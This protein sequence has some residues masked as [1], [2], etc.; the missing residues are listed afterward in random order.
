M[1]MEMVITKPAIV[2]TVVYVVLTDSLCRGISEGF[3]RQ[4]GSKHNIYIYY[5][6]LKILS[7]IE[8]CVTHGCDLHAS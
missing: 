8:L 2:F 5:C 3:S 1:E 7:D 6:Q 4:V